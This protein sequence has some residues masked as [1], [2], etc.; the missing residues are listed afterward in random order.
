MYNGQ[1]LGVSYHWFALDR[2]I[3]ILGSVCWVFTHQKLLWIY[4]Q[5]MPF[6]SSLNVAIQDKC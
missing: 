5:R 1:Y 2:A 4:V 3:S 6:L